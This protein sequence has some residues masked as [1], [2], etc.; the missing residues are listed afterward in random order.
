[1]PKFSSELGETLVRSNRPMKEFEV[2]DETPGAS[3][4]TVDALNRRFAERNMQLPPGVAEQFAK[5]A[6]AESEPVI[7]EVPQHVSHEE[8]LVHEM[9]QAKKEKGKIDR[10]SPGAK[11]RIEQLLGMMRLTKEVEMNGIIFS[12]RTLN[13][14]E[15]RSV[16]HAAAQYDGTVETPFELRKQT[17]SYALEKINGDR[18]ADFLGSP[19]RSVILEFL[20][21]LDENAVSILFRNYTSLSNETDKRYG[22]V[23]DQDAKEVLEDLKK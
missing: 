23:S 9:Y 19:D 22:I 7:Q 15:S 16:L 13:A 14:E 20:D 21:E 12:L 18:I 3:N 6:Y 8:K 10:L 2:P 17:L 1:M 4:A 11:K 5:R